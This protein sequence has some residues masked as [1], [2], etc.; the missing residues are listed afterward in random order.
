MLQ[1]QADRALS[2]AQNQVLR[3]E[4]E[5]AAAQSKMGSTNRESESREKEIG[6]LQGD[7]QYMKL[8]LSKIDKEKDNL[9]V[10]ILQIFVK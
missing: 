6:R 7:V 1:E 2:D 5:L 10:G 8:Q 3:L 4:T 9:L